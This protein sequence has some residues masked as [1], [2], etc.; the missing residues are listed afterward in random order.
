M[1]KNVVVEREL[2]AGNVS[3]EKFTK[4]GDRCALPGDK[5]DTLA[6][7]CL[8]VALTDISSSLGERIGINLAR[9]VRLDSLFNLTVGTLCILL[10]T[11]R[12]RSN[13][14]L[15][16]RGKPRTLEETILTDNEKEGTD[17]MV[18]VEERDGAQKADA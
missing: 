17:E 8:P 4:Q 16:I 12:V 7:Y 18:G 14:F 6:L 1:V 13:I 5:V 10:A 3:D 9:P 15:P 11:S 2:A